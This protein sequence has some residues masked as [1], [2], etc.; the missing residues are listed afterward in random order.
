MTGVWIVWDYGC[1]GGVGHVYEI[2]PDEID[3]L[4][5]VNRQGYGKVMFVEFG[6]VNYK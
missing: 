3:A 1:G 5:V 4:R 6:E 2:Y